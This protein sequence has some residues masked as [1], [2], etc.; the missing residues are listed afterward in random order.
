MMSHGELLDRLRRMKEAGQTTNAEI[1]R[2]IGVPSSRVADI[3]ATD[4]KP[5]KITIDEAKTL[6]ERLGI[7][8]ETPQAPVDAET[9]RA[10]LQAILDLTPPSGMDQG[11][12]LRALSATLASGFELLGCTL[13]VPPTP[14]AMQVALR[15][16][17]SRAR[18]LGLKP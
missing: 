12:I 16:V 1:G 18:D 13:P 10:L 17:A 7:N 4:R 15:G 14:E 2:I 9:V 8:E 11:T 6:V 3:F 5:R